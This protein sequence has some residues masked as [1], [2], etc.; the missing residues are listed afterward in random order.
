MLVTGWIR[1]SSV[2]LLSVGLLMGVSGCWSAPDATTSAEYMALQGAAI[3][4]IFGCASAYN[5]ASAH[6]EA[7]AFSIGC[8]AGLVAGAVI[9]GVAGY[10]LYG[11]APKEWEP[12][13]KPKPA[14]SSISPSPEQSFDMKA[15]NADLLNGPVQ[16][17]R[18][19][20]VTDLSS[21]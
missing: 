3:G 11:P 14:T 9:G 6:H 1:K 15:D 2:G 20:Q 17:S 10:A 19:R 21:L 8:P 5:F 12:P 13:A 7:T 16:A 4:S 18:E